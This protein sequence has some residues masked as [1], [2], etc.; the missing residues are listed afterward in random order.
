MENCQAPAKGPPDR[1]QEVLSSLRSALGKDEPTPKQIRIW[2]Y[3]VG[4]PVLDQA[5]GFS[6]MLAEQTPVS[7]LIT[8]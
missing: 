8:A 5:V 2:S 7:F 1:R 4:N 6:V 3:P